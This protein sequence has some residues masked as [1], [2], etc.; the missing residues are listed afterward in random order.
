MACAIHTDRDSVAIC[1][2]CGSELCVECRTVVGGRNFCPTCAPQQEA[3]PP[4]AAEPTA[5]GAAAPAT[6]AAGNELLA[7]LCYPIWIVAV[8]VLA[9]DMKKD[10]Y[11]RTHAWQGV[12]WAIAWAVVWAGIV[13][14]GQIP[15]VGMLVGLAG[16]LASL[17]WLVLS[18][19]YAVKAYNR[20]EVVIPIIT[21]MA[22][23]QYTKPV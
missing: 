4:P 3:A 5:P 2:T 6:A 9:T 18:I 20:Q 11:M 19:L 1:V 15:I 23:K 17:G 12:F 10:A 14:L 21:E 7:A 16:A 13:V 8:I 22:A